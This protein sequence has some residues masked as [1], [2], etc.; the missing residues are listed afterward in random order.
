MSKF[1]NYHVMKGWQASEFAN[2]KNSALIETYKKII[3]KHRSRDIDLALDFGF[4]NGEMLQTLRKLGVQGIY[5]I[6]ANINLVHLANKNG[7]Y[8]FKSVDEIPKEV[9]QKFDLIVAMHVM[10]HIDYD[11]LRLIFTSLD[12]L[13][14]PGGSVV[15][16]F[17]NGESPFSNFA[18]NS[19]PTHINSLTREK[20]RLLCQN[21]SIRL[22]SYQ[23]FPS[24]G[25]L[26]NRFHTRLS[27]HARSFC[28]RIVYF[29]L[30]KIIYGSEAVLL[31]PIALAVW[32]KEEKS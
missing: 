19:D 17:P 5:G 31:S 29:I 16:A 18:F 7:Y 22:V 15:A 28:E 10:E 30:N 1:D 27:A 6:E 25:V 8:A 26:S 3:K 20:C 24:L 9:H 2:G 14:R 21:T 32:G 13:L 12:G 11:A 4:G 23:E